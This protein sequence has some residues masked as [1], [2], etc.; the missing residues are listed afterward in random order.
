VGYPQFRQPAR[1]VTIWRT[2][3]PLTPRPDLVASDRRFA[4]GVAGASAMQGDLRYS[5]GRSEHGS[6]ADRQDARTGLSSRSSQIS[7]RARTSL[8]QPIPFATLLLRNLR[9]GRIES[10]VRA[11]QNGRFQ[12]DTLVSSRYVVELLGVD[13]AVLAASEFGASGESNGIVRVSA[14]ATPRALFGPM[15][16]T[17][18]TTTG[19]TLGTSSIGSTSN[20]NG[21]FSSTASEPLGRAAGQGIRQTT[22]PDEEASPRN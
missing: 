19:T 7:G 11:D 10:R 21:F 16:T 8:N 2:A 6:A 18:G 17:T 22:Q 4:Y 15:G 1:P 12:F 3:G 20:G 14:N 5:D 9:T 13:G